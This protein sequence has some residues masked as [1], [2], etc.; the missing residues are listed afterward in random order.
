M[1]GRSRIL[2]NGHTSLEDCIKR[3]GEGEVVPIPPAKDALLK[4][5]VWNSRNPF[6]RRFQWL[7]CEVNFPGDGDDV[8]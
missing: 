8:R 2:P 7:P 3:C 6:S 4:D 5:D 1:Y